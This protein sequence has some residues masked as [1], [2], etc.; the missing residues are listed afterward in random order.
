[1]TRRVVIAGGAGHIGRRLAAALVERGDDVVV[2]S[3]DP[4][5][6]ARH[7]PIP[8]RLAPWSVD[9][10]AGLARLL[11]G[12]DAVVGVTGVPVGPRPWTARRRQAIR[13]SR[14]E[15][16][17]AIV[18]AIR[19]LAPER[20]PRV[21]VSVSGT[22]GYEGQDLVPATEASPTGRG[23]LAK[24]CADWEAAA[25]EANALGVRVA[26]TR[27]GFVLAPDATVMRLFALP[28]RFF[29]GGP[30]GSGR[31]WFSWIHVDDVVGLLT[32]AIDDPRAQGSINAVSP[33]PIHQ[34]DLAAA[35][36][37]A[38]HRPSWLRIPA[39]LIRL[40]MRE[41]SI[42]ALGSRRIVP[43]RALELGYR[44]RWTDLRAAVRD[45]LDRGDG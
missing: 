35:V 27:I 41:S 11:D 13:T 20:R 40:V 30:L 7:G 28:F 16:T 34:A 38:L 17:H 6:A 12:A 8:G 42:L 4:D 14:L 5:R 23:F 37:A 3:R 26:I 33:E 45:I 21:L 43:V 1:V 9:D 29:L 19:T 44:F 2:L 25:S 10:P 31:Q 36:G 18:E 22:D 15:P 24:L 32:L 39:V